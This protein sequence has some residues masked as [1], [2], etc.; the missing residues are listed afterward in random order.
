M[1]AILF[2]YCFSRLIPGYEIFSE[3][4]RFVLIIHL[5]SCSRVEEILNLD[6]ERQNILFHVDRGG[7]S[8]SITAKVTVLYQDRPHHGYVVTNEVVVNGD[9]YIDVECEGMEGGGLDDDSSVS[10]NNQEQDLQVLRLRFPS[11]YNENNEQGWRSRTFIEGKGI[12]IIKY[13]YPIR[14]R[15][16]KKTGKAAFCVTRVNYLKNNTNQINHLT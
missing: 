3:N 8:W 14:I 4:A 13:Y 15:I 2:G 1:C 11:Y 16:N 5:H 10:S 6:Q 12:I 9:H 7:Y